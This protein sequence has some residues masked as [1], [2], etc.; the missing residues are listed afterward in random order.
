[1]VSGLLERYLAVEGAFSGMLDRG[2]EVIG[3]LMRD[4]ARA[5]EAQPGLTALQQRRLA[6]DRVYDALVRPAALAALAAAAIT[7]VSP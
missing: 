2:E 1:V 4:A 5:A 7:A 3:T 6:C